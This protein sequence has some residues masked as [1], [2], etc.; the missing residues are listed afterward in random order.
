M[1]RQ[2]IGRGTWLD[3]VAHRVL[4]K[5][6]QLDRKPAVIKTES[7]LGASGI[8]HVGSLSDGVRSY[9]I[10]LAVETLGKKAEYVAFSDDLDGLRR[11]P[12]GM[13]ASLATYL[14]YPVTSIPDPFNCHES[15]GEHMSSLLREALDK[16]GIE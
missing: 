11:V 1:S 8:P 14:G 9:A 6:D 10:K 4:E 2:T 15:Y 12:A 5:E 13:P 3:L 7:G 16:C